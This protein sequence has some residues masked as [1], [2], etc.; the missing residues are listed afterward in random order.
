M[1]GPTLES[2]FDQGVALLGRR[3]GTA[4]PNV[5]LGIYL[6]AWH[7]DHG[8]DP[9]TSRVRD[10]GAKPTAPAADNF[11]DAHK[12][13]V[14]LIA[15][16][17]R[18]LAGNAAPIVVPAPS[19][20]GRMLTV[21]TALAQRLGDGP[22][23][24]VADLLR[25]RPDRPPQTR[26]FGTLG[27]LM[28]TAGQFEVTDP[29]AVR[30]RTIVLVDDVLATGSTVQETARLLRDAGAAHVLVVTLAHS[31]Q[32]RPTPPPPDPASPAR[33]EGRPFS[34]VA[35]ALEPQTY[36]AQMSE[37]AKLSMRLG[38]L[39]ALIKH[40]GTND[41]A[42]RTLVELLRDP[43]PELV[44]PALEHLKTLHLTEPNGVRE[45][46]ELALGTRELQVPE[47][48]RLPLL[49]EI[50]GLVRDRVNSTDVGPAL[51]STLEDLAHGRR[52]MHLPAAMRPV[53][54]EALAGLLAHNTAQPETRKLVIDLLR[55]NLRQGETTAPVA[56]PASFLTPLQEQL[57]SQAR[58]VLES[59]SRELAPA[60]EAVRSMLT[61]VLEWKDYR[62]ATELGAHARRNLRTQ[63]FDA[64]QNQITA[65][66]TAF[67]LRLAEIAARETTPGGRGVADHFIPWLEGRGQTL[68]RVF[69]QDAPG[70]ERFLQALDTTIALRLQRTEDPSLTLLQALRARFR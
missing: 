14:A 46:V 42:Q 26:Q 31:T 23:P 56:R 51:R 44:E 32:R 4:D 54:F 20:D 3:Q 57:L 45:L 7:P 21:A 35:R 24:V 15:S 1:N 37:P 29:A 52:S 2:V 40:W 64:L 34:E 63:A 50:Q 55:G 58:A 18:T 68:A 22:T 69:S 70:R 10:F 43:A 5:S 19:S 33:F 38:A 6:P 28:N 9:H 36:P 12:E 16:D 17:I 66:D 53:T 41:N 13:H 8:T 30:G 39:K 65:G 67:C 47:D 11:L 49:M 60:R 59:S 61:E 48:A 25:E 62:T 27:R